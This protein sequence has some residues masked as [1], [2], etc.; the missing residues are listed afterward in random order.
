MAIPSI[1]DLHEY[2]HD[3]ARCV[4]MLVERGVFY[5]SIKCTT[6]GDDM[7]IYLGRQVYRCSR[8]ACRRERSLRKFTFFYGSRLTCAKIMHLAYFWIT[9]VSS[10]TAQTIT[11]HSKHTIGIF[12]AHFRALVASSLLPD[13]TIIGGD[14]VIVEVDETKL[15]K[16]KYNR[17]HKVN[18][19]WILGGVERTAERKV[20]LIEIESRDQNTLLNAI[21]R[22]VRSGSIVHTDLWKGYSNISPILGLEHHT[23]NHSLT[24]K[25]PEDGTHTNTIEGTNNGLKISIKPR[26]RTSDGICGHLMEFIWRRKNE[27]DLWSGFIDALRD[28]HYEFE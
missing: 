6:C 3:D 14:G 27:G 21:S 10:N 20:F 25:N 17:G 5:P 15:G 23:V 12:Y 2:F 16:R 4:E 18:G 9:G 8:N 7:R 22:H 11:G 19:V 1:Y 28:V 24:F 13:D 26:N